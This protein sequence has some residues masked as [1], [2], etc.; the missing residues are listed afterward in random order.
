MGRYVLETVLPASCDEVWNLHARP[1]A[2]HDLSPPGSVEIIEAGP[3]ADDAQVVM[4][5]SVPVV[6][7]RLTWVSRY[8]EVR[9]PHGYVDVAVGGLFA[10]W[11]HRHALEPHPG[12]CLVREEVT[13]EAPAGVLGEVVAGPLVRRMLDGQLGYRHARLTSL[14]RE[15]ARAGG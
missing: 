13:Y 14:V 6:P 12:G 1:N 4:L 9:P 10:S 11:R 2:L 5:V 15:L 8:A 7:W 3:L